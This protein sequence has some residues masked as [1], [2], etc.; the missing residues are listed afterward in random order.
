[1]SLILSIESRNLSS[2][3]S[4]CQASP[5]DVLCLKFNK[6]LLDFLNTYICSL[7]LTHDIVS[8]AV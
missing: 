8:D 2:R 3:N 6:N 1:M 7:S 4:Y 5:V